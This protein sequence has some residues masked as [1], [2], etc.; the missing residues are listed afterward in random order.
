VQLNYHKANGLKGF[1]LLTQIGQ[2]WVRQCDLNSFSVDETRLF[3]YEQGSCTVVANIQSNN[4][5]LVELLR[6]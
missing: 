4:K 3:S 1:I 2:I 6:L 5:I